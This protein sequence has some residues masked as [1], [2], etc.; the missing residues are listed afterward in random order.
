LWEEVSAKFIDYNKEILQQC[1]GI[2]WITPE[3]LG[4]PGLL[5]KGEV[6]ERDRR[7]LTALIMHQKSRTTNRM[8]IRK[9]ETESNWKFQQIFDQNMRSIGMYE[10][11]CAGL[12]VD[13]ETVDVEKES[14]YLYKLIVV[15]SV[16]NSDIDSLYQ[17]TESRSGNVDFFT[18]KRN[19][20]AHLEANKFQDPDRMD[21]VRTK[22]FEV[23]SWEDILFE[24]QWRS[25]AVAGFR[26]L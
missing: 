15:N 8:V 11:P 13:G 7:V 3:Y 10:Q 6:S 5:P 26:N 1:P 17:P 2:S 25:Y 23:K 18:Q 22:M 21:A 20:Y 14:D 24:G 19:I 9:P 4:G 16:I 12:I